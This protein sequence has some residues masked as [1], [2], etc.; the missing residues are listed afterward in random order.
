MD[1]C[2]GDARMTTSHPASVTCM[3]LELLTIARTGP[4]SGT[5]AV[6]VAPEAATSKSTDEEEFERSAVREL[7]MYCG[8]TVKRRSNPDEAARGS[9]D[10]SILSPWW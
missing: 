8:H 7:K 6:S 1:L 3:S 4:L 10:R 2:L 5:D 9:A